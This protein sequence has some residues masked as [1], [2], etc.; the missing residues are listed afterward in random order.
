M[1]VSIFLLVVLSLNIVSAVCC[2]K[3]NDGAWCQNIAPEFANECDGNFLQSNSICES[4]SFCKIGT[5][6]NYEFGSCTTT[7]GAVCDSDEGD[8]RAADVEDIAECRQGCCIF[9]DQASFVT[10]VQCVYQAGLSEV[11]VEPRFL[12]DSAH[13]TSEKCI[14][15]ANSQEKGACVYDT[16]QGRKCSHET[17]ETCR[18]ND[19]DFH[20]EI[21]CSAPELRT[22]CGPTERTTCDE[23]KD[24]VFF[25]DTC[26]NVANVYDFDKKDDDDYWTYMYNSSGI[27]NIV[28]PDDSNSIKECGTCHYREGGTTCAAYDPREDPYEPKVGDFVC[29][30]IRCEYDRDGDGTTEM[31]NHGESWC[32]SDNIWAPGAP[33]TEEIKLRCSNGKVLPEPCE[34]WRNQRCNETNIGTASDPELFAACIPNRWAGCVNSNTKEIC[35]AEDRDCKWLYY[36]ADPSIYDSIWANNM[37]AEGISKSEKGLCVP[38]YPPAISFWEESSRLQCEWMQPVCN[39]KFTKNPLGKWKIDGDALC[40]KDKSYDDDDFDEVTLDTSSD[41]WQMELRNMCS[42]LGDCGVKANYI[43]EGGLNSWA[44]LYTG[45]DHIPSSVIDALDDGALADGTLASPYSGIGGYYDG[46][47]ITPNSIQP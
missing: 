14:A 19:R 3:T 43:G 12:T 27:C 2:E 30:D 40:F 25:V 21:L 22:L 35:D 11:Y 29:R 28:D 16:D 20:A 1:L 44:D 9:D 10:Q 41:S 37:P 38:K 45:T 31:Y 26:D 24:E 13:D 32:V 42:A 36:T 33:G 23:Y 4:T 7:T 18:N 34:P 8:W 5:C 6:V 15:A 17:R 47:P 46:N 39:V